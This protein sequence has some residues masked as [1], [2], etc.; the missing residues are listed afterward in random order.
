MHLYSC[1][2]LI[3]KFAVKTMTGGLSPARWESISISTSFH[4]FVHVFDRVNPCAGRGGLLLFLLVVGG[5][6]ILLHG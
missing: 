3:H 6:S 5:Y 1:L 2:E 4:F